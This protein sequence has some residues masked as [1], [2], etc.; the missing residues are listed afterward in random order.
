MSE[1]IAFHSPL[2]PLAGDDLPD[3]TG[4]PR[5]MVS[6]PLDQGHSGCATGTGAA[7]VAASLA[8]A[9]RH[10]TWR[11]PD[12]PVVFVSDAHADA[13]GFLR[14]LVAAGAI[15][16]DRAQPRQ[17]QL[18]PFGRT[19]KIVV[20]GDCLDKGPSN[21]DLLAAL[22]ALIDTGADVHLLAGNHD[23]RFLVALM[24]LERAPCGGVAATRALTEHLFIR[25]GRKA[26]PLL[27]EVYGKHVAPHG[28]P[29]D[30]P[31]EAACKAILYPGDDWAKR[32]ERAAKP[33][34]KGKARAREIQ[35]GEKKRRTFAEAAED[36]GLTMRMILA[37]ARAC[38]DLFLGNGDLSWFYGRM[39]AVTRTGSILFVHAGLDDAAC[40]LLAEDGPDA[41]NHAFLDEA[42]RD[43]FGF[44]FGAV[45]N[46]MRTKYRDSDRTLT[47]QGVDDLLAT[48]VKMV[49]QG[50]VNN[51]A[52]QRLLAKNGLL[53]LEGDVSLDAGTR[54]LEGLAGHGAGATLIYPTGDMV[55]LCADFPMAKHFHPLHHGQEGP[56]Q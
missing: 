36:Y 44:Y 55:G 3:M 26:M 29:A 28:L 9:A 54:A 53:H 8:R 13:D 4:L 43:P 14:S 25:L 48:G 19:A 38:R 30:L 23:L 47:E 24:A 40:R 20:G 1:P 41:V 35:R 2:L 34:L 45:A 10:G 16:R 39:Q 22:K 18:T 5:G 21:L 49:V 46:M 31:D 6:W 51:H 56:R 17:F 42:L 32:F 15:R 12:R 27:A 7:S 52:G 11:F 37:A 50:H 33:Y